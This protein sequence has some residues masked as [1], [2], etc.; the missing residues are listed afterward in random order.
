ML[1][2]HKA[3]D[4][5]FFPLCHESATR[6]DSAQNNQSCIFHCV[7]S[8]KRVL[9]CASLSLRILFPWSM[10]CLQ[11]WLGL[12]SPGAICVFIFVGSPR[13]V[14]S[15]LKLWVKRDKTLINSFGIFDSGMKSTL[16][17]WSTTTVEWWLACI[18]LAYLLCRFCLL[19]LDRIAGIDRLIDYRW[20]WCSDM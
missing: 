8:L 7:W 17:W 18:F 2:S 5:F 13:Q 11:L 15:D 6:T 4:F 12:K 10:T 20:G 9:S 1:A 3:S 16:R 19:L 14:L